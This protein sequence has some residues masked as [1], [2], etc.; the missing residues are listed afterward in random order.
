MLKQI[1][2][3]LKANNATTALISQ[4]ESLKPVNIE[5]VKEFLVTDEE[6]KKY[7]QSV[8]DSVVTKAI[9]TYKEKTLP[10]LVDEEV[11]KRFPQESEEKKELKKIQSRMQQMEAELKKKELLNKAIQIANEKKLPLKLVE[12]F[13]GEDEETTTKNLDELSTVFSDHAKSIVE[14]QFKKGGRATPPAANFDKNGW[15]LDKIGNLTKEELEKNR[16]SINQ[17]LATQNQ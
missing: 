15:T 2:E 12:R 6:G 11:N 8:T 1:I 3:F 14:E 7:L 16:E 17:F 9:S 5:T 4:A 10:S 13:L